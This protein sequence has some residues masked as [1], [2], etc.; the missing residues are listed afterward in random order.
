MAA[1]AADK[2]VT[3]IR[4]KVDARR[5]LVIR[6]MPRRVAVSRTS[7]AAATAAAAAASKTPPA[8]AATAATEPSPAA[9]AQAVDAQRV[10]LGFQVL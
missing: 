8:A 2:A 7:A 10:Q 5:A 1:V 9:T 3:V 4:S 6:P